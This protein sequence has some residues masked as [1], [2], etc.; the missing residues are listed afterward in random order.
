MQKVL[1]TQWVENQSRVIAV[2]ESLPDFFMELQLK[3]EGNIVIGPL[4]S[5]VTPQ[6]TFKIWKGGKNVRVDFTF[7]GVSIKNVVKSRENL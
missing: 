1:H 7:K 2:L 5:L 6:E 3:C 4:V